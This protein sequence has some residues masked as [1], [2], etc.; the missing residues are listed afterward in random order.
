MLFEEM[1]DISI[2]TTFGIG[3]SVIRCDEQL[4][5]CVICKRETR[6]KDKALHLY[7]CSHECDKAVWDEYHKEMAN[8]FLRNHI[9]VYKNEIKEDLK[10]IELCKDQ[11]KDILIV[12]HDQLDYLKRTIESIVK[13]TSNYHI[14]I[15][16]NHS[17]QDTQ[18]YLH[19]LMFDLNGK[20]T[21][22]R[23]ETNLGFIE[24][25]N[26]L[27]ALGDSDYIILLNSDTE[28][29]GGWDKAMLGYLQNNHDVKLVG[30]QGGL[31]NSKGIGGRIGFGKD[32]DYI[33]GWCLCM[34]RDTYDKHGLFSS[35]LKF[36]YAEDSDLSI[37]LQT[38]GYQIYAL[39]LMLVKHFENKT[40]SNVQAEKEVDVCATFEYNHQ[41]LSKKWANYI[42][43]Q[44]IDVRERKS[45]EEALDSII[46]SF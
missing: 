27:A 20:I 2:G 39:H 23:S 7:V 31:I 37:R 36:A 18:D 24:P 46:N 29:S 38:E 40:I 26:E 1:E 3:N 35:D 10:H 21:V 44:R 14:Y 9:Q 5:S 28:V 6:F 30:Y 19:Q 45:G 41:I 43:N 13:F 17:K 25:N 16:D 8:D 4:S 22:M 15:W 12:V 11:T 32:V 42:E 33:A 34:E